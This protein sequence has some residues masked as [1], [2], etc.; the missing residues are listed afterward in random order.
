MQRS[1]P[2]LLSVTAAL[3]I[4]TAAV[5]TA[6]AQ[7]PEIPDARSSRAD[8]KNDP[9]AKSLREMVTNQQITRR[10]KEHEEM[11]KQGDDALKISQELENSLEQNPTLTTKDVQKLQELEKI[12][13]KIREELGAKDKIDKIEDISEDGS[14][15]AARQSVVTAFKFLRSSTIKLVDELKKSTRFSISVAA[16]QASNAV[17]KFARFL[18]L[19]K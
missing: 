2:I 7:I 12:V 5:G 13:S 17:V 1:V 18:Q 6:S 4:G 8:E 14:E 3:F 11:L 15:N 10:K 9:E 19:K 16:I